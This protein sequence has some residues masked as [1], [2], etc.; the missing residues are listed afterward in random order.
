MPLPDDIAVAE[1][2]QG[3]IEATIATMEFEDFF[4]A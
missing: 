4:A 2:L 3:R 1:S